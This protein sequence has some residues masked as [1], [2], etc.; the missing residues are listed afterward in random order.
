MTSG[1]TRI[2]QSPREPISSEIARRLLDYLFSGDVH[3]GDRIP[4][5]RQLTIDLGVNRPSVREAIRALGFLGLL[6]VRQGSGTYFRGPDQELLFRL[7]EWNLVFGEGHLPDLA[8]ARAQLEVVVAGLAAE[9]R[10]PEQVAELK[11]ILKQMRSSSPDEFV[12]ADLAFHMTIAA[13]AGNT[14]LRDMLKG[15]RAMVQTWVSH[16]VRAAATTKIAFADHPPI[17]KAIERGDAEAARQAM[18]AHMDGATRR[19]LAGVAA[20]AAATKKAGAKPA[21][22]A[23]VA[24]D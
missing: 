20:D 22:K 8:E 16:N 6:E 15:V 1:L 11:A 19:L 9:R 24:G 3:P 4:S 18:S 12:E 21:R 7:F 14:A 23:G 5:E 2:D 10:T 17:L 13:M